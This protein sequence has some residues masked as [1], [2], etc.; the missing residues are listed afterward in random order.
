[1]ASFFTIQNY[2]I[3]HL[4]THHVWVYRGKALAHTHTHTCPTQGRS[5]FQLHKI[6][7]PL[8]ERATAKDKALR[9]LTCHTAVSPSNLPIFAKIKITVRKRK[10]V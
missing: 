5:V 10:V 1:L 4:Q 8:S 3:R 9:P 2:F 7:S 6:Y